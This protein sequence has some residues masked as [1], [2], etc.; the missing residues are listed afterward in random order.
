LVAGRQRSS[1]RCR[2]AFAS[3][4]IAAP[5]AVAF[6]SGTGRR[7]ENAGTCDTFIVVTI[8]KAGDA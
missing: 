4:I 7:V 6:A 8:D 5:F 2:E 1:S 3:A